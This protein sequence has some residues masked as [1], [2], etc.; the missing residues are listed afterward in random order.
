MKGQLVILATGC[1]VD[2]FSENF[3][4]LI[5]DKK[6]HYQQINKNEKMD[7]LISNLDNK[8]WGL[9]NSIFIETYQLFDCRSSQTRVNRLFCAK[10]KEALNK[11]FNIFIVIPDAST[12]DKR[13]KKQAIIFSL[14]DS[15]DRS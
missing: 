9:S 6:G 2:N 14:P 11:G 3:S 13:L 10:V 4:H 12:V 15:G 8:D 7:S 1:M 5:K